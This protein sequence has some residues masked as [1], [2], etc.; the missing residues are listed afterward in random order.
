M[1]DYWPAHADVHVAVA[2][3]ALTSAVTL[4]FY[5]GARTIAVVEDAKHRMIIT[6]DGKPIGNYPVSL[7]APSTPTSGASR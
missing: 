4:D 7:G 2:A 3:N 5:T 1:R 6:R